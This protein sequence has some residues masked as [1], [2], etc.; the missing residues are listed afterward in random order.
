MSIYDDALNRWDVA[1]LDFDIL[2]DAKMHSKHRWRAKC[3]ELKTELV[4]AQ[5]EIKQLCDLLKRNNIDYL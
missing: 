2:D 1:D 3:I 5:A 4:A